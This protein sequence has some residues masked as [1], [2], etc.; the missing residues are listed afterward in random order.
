MQI[1]FLA[2][3]VATTAQFVIG[4]VWYMPL[5]GKIWGQIHGFDALSKEEQMKAQKKMMPLLAIQFIMGLVSVY[6]LSALLTVLPEMV[7]YQITLWVWAGFMLPVQVS[8]VLF[9]GTEQKWI[10]KKLGVMLGGSFVTFLGAAF[11]LSLF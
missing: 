1:N 8:A 9:G 10:M 2:I 3:F 4:A 5:F 6:A 11:I 7:W